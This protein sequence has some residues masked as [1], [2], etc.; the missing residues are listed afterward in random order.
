[1]IKLEDYVGHQ[2]AGYAYAAP[3]NYHPSRAVV[4]SVTRV[5]SDK[6]EVSF[7]DDDFVG[8]G[9]VRPLW[10]DDDEIMTSLDSSPILGDIYL[11]ELGGEFELELDLFK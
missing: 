6:L 9:L 4:G 5:V 7:D 8:T 3:D 2:L 1:M 11:E 10:I